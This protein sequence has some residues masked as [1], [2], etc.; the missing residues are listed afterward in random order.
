MY[1]SSEY[2]HVFHSS[3]SCFALIPLPQTYMRGRI[4]KYFKQFTKA[5]DFDQQRD[6]FSKESQARVGQRIFQSCIFHYHTK[7]FFVVE[8]QRYL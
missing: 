6:T 8:N 1:S 5:A 3:G 4:A 2:V 7:H